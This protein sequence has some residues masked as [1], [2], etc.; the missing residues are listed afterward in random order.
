MEDVAGRLAGLSPEKRELLE[1]LLRKKRAQAAASAAIRPR[2][3]D[4]GPLPLSFSQERLWLTDQLEPD[5][6]AYNIPVSL[7]FGGELSLEALRESLGAVRRRHESLRTRFELL[8]GRPVQVI[9]PPFPFVLPLVDLEGLPVARR[10]EEVLRLAREDA[11]RPFDLRQGPV[12]RSALVRLSGRD[13][14]LLSAVHHIV[15]DG[16]STGIFAREVEGLYAALSSGLPATLPPLPI[17]YADFALWQRRNLEGPALEA[18]L[19]FWRRQL[20]G[21]EPVLELPSDRPRPP[22]RTPRGGFRSWSLPA[23]LSRDL[24]E[25]SGREETTPFTVLLAGFFALLHHQTRRDDLCVGTPVAGRRQV[26]TEGLIGFFVNTLVL[27]ADLSGD[28]AFRQLLARVHQGVLDAQSNQDVPFERLVSELACERSLSY[29][30]IFQVLF[31]LQQVAGSASPLS[32][33]LSAP[34]GAAK[35]DL[36]LLLND[37]GV[38]IG[39]GMEYSLDLFDP[40]TIDRLL[41]QLHRL[42]E[43]IVARPEGR[44]S[45]IPLLSPAERHQLLVEWAMTG[46][47]PARGV[48]LHEL[49]AAQAART[50]DAVALVHGIRTLTYGELA[51]RAGG[52]ARR[53]RSLGAGPETRVAV[54][55]ERSPDL[56]AA[57]LG[58]L[59]AGAAYVPI[60]PAYPAD[61]QAFMLEDS[62]AAVL[63]T[64]GPLAMETIV[65][66]L[67]AEE[68]P[69]SSLP[70]DVGA[71]PGNL[72]YVIYTS[73]STGRPKGVAVE[74][75]SAVTLAG[76][77][78]EQF[79]DEELAGVLASTSV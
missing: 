19:D 73:G 34:S 74:H 35:F 61:R 26:E 10:E 56:I 59:A 40:A 64:R 68:I 25:L 2:S 6:P 42:L 55:L 48:C 72:A 27:R 9:D 16:W 12:F 50:P 67:E 70:G 3:G 45:E 43:G 24:R 41:G 7:R 75:R 44:L 53:L 13:H 54:C 33:A 57:L 32:R 46:E 49:F 36:S 17:Q 1:A 5:N 18:Q 21:L 22:R 78:R 60:D 11:A 8:E 77:A 14:A 28:P 37:D 38:E 23:G 4:E 65:L 76:W 69:G 62:G 39:G 29:T 79:S 20:A 47:A 66:D 15:S 58:V 31:A 30:P 63:I 52:I 51:A 71:T